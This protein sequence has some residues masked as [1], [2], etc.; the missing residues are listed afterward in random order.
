MPPWMRSAHKDLRERFIFSHL[1]LDENGEEIH[2]AGCAARAVAYFEGARTRRAYATVC[3]YLQNLPHKYLKPATLKHHRRNLW[4]PI[5]FS[6]IGFQFHYGHLLAKDFNYSF[7]NYSRRRRHITVEEL[8]QE[9]P[10][11]LVDIDEHMLLLEEG[12]QVVFCPK[13]KFIGLMSE[14]K[15]P[16][17]SRYRVLG[18]YLRKKG[19]ADGT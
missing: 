19:V 18:Y 6:L 8:A 2:A 3:S 9:H 11:C 17:Y 4:F 15:A 10:D 12:K 7:H 5:E 1:G 13:P 14:G 16:D